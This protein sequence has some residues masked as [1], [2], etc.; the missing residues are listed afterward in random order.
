MQTQ[1]HTCRFIIIT[2]DA[3]FL[4]C[5]ESIYKVRKQNAVSLDYF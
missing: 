5:D 2:E 3:N 1:T 4:K